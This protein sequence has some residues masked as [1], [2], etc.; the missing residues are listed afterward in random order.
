MRKI[1]TFL[2][3]LLTLCG[4]VQAQTT[5]LKILSED[6]L[7]AGSTYLMVNEDAKVALGAISSTTTPYGTTVS[8]TI[9]DG[10]ITINDEAVDVLT[11]GGTAGEWTLASSL[12]NGYI[13]WT[14]GNS[15]RLQTEVNEKAQWAISFSNGDVTLTNVS[16]NARVLSYNASSPRFATYGNT[17]QKR[18][19]LYRVDNTAPDEVA[20][21][22]ISPAT[23]TYYTAQEVTITAVEGA[24]IYYTTNGVDPKTS[25]AIYAAPFSVTETT[26]V[27]AVAA[28]GNN[29]SEVA[30]SVITI[31]TLQTQTIADVIAAGAADQANTTGTVVGICKS[32]FLIGDGS[33][34]IFVYTGSAPTVVV[35]DV[36]VVTGKVSAYGGC[37]Q[38]SSATISKSG[39]AQVDYPQ[40]T[41]IDGQAFDALVATPAVTFVK[42]SGTMTSV[43]SYNNFTIE[44]ATVT[45]SILTTANGMGDIAVNDEVTVTGFFVYQSGSGKYGNIIAVNIEKTGSAETP[46]YNTLAA[47]KDAVTATG[48]YVQLNLTEC[49]VTFVKGQN[50]YLYDGKDGLLVYGTNSDIKAGDKISGTIKGQLVLYQG[51]TELSNPTYSVQVV[52]SEN[53]VEPQVI[54]IGD[55]QNAKD[56]E[57]ELVTIEELT[58]QAAAF[59]SKNLIFMDEDDS[60]LA[61]H[62]K[63]NVMTDA[64]F[65]TAATYNVTGFVNIYTIDSESTI[66]LY[67]RM[68]EDIVNPNEEELQTPEAAWEPAGVQVKMGETV[69]AT[70]TTNSDG[71]ISYE[72]SNPAVATVDNQGN[73]TIVGA[74]SAKITATVEATDKFKSAVAVLEIAVTSDADGTLANP[75]TVDDVKAL[76]AAT[77]APKGWARG[78]IVGY[79]SG[80]IKTGCKFTAEGAVNTNILLAASASETDYNN[81]VPVELQNKD[82]L[83]EALSLKDHADYLKKEV[84]IYGSLTPYFSVPGV[85]AVT[86][87]SL[88]GVTEANPAEVLPVITPATGTYETAQEVTITVAEGYAIYYTLDG[89]DPTIDSGTLY[90][91]PFTVEVTTTVKAIAV[92]PT[93]GN[94]SKV[95][96]SVITISQG[97]QE[98]GYTKISDI[99]A[100]ATADKTAVTYNAQD[101]LVTYVNGKSLYVYDGTDGLLLFGTNSGIAVGDKISVTVKGNLYLYN[102]LTE[103]ADVTYSDLTKVS[104]GNEVTAQEVEISEL[105]QNFKAFENELVTIKDVKPA[106][107]AWTKKN[108]TF[109]DDSDNEIVLRDNWSV[110]TDVAFDTQKTYNI[111]GFVAIYVNS[112]ESTIQ[113]YPRKKADID[114]G[115]TPEVYVFTGDGSLEN[116]YTVE[117]IQHKEATDTKNALEKGVWV[118]AYIVGYING[119]SLNATTAI[120]SAEA[121]TDGAVTASNILIADAADANAVAN[122]IP[123]ALPNNADARADLNLSDNPDKLG[124][125]VWLKGNIIKYM[126]VP[127]LREVKVYSLDGLNIVDAIKGVASEAVPATQVIYNLAGQRLQNLNKAGIY[128]VNGKKVAVK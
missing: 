60:E 76:S 3:A 2:V 43:G 5:Y 17:N 4:V 100:A 90:T 10:S 128:I 94:A 55:L 51:V 13:A 14:S 38:F 52:S 123:V 24:T 61:V 106:E 92:P 122:V 32:G 80:G 59:E 25:D 35:G 87:W 117:D 9:S 22:R 42:V 83:R 18:V 27:K 121:P 72:S 15:L 110:A 88:D 93:G 65:N 44:G 6:D 114:N 115:E 89:T 16:D 11:L 78:Y 19:Q 37:M 120:F 96:S 58:P 63:F 7:V 103:I 69:T 95:V 1:Y 48:E 20:K 26:T 45:G 66:Q 127:G 28:K 47:A 70:F 84:W 101:V 119:S 30:E 126:G 23:G 118:K 97:Q 109:T 81:C 53:V 33:G 86:N 102:G 124:T 71:A 105:T 21:P 46:E 54:S 82:G 39:T 91:T 104:E 67:P 41:V 112:E 75:Y 31:E 113:I 74:G 56:Y 40:A 64:A 125:Q 12:A 57:S 49:L 77:D 34:Y 79:V 108:M 73:I 29:M 107:E 8:V 116:P 68:A 36:V 85:K 50:L 111:T 98:E 99:K 62:D